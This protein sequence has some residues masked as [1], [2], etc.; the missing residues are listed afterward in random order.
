MMN[1]MET[2]KTALTAT[3]DAKVAAMIEKYKEMLLKR[4]ESRIQFMEKVSPY[5]EKYQ[6]SGEIFSAYKLGKEL[7]GKEYLTQRSRWGGTM[8]SSEA[9]SLSSQLG[10]L[11]SDLHKGGSI[12][13][14]DGI[15][16]ESAPKLYRF[17]K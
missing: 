1:T 6:K 11:L 17:K 14:V 13:L 10:A 4:M 2:M 9:I 5:L 15:A 12:E 3:V 16:S 7:M 8:R